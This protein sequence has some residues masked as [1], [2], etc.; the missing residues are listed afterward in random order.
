M[1]ARSRSSCSAASP[2]RYAAAARDASASRS[3]SNEPPLRLPPRITCTPPSNAS[4]PRTADDTLVAFESF[5]YR[6]PPTVPTSSSRCGTPANVRSAAATA[7][8]GTPDAI[9][10]AAAPR[11][12][13]RLCSPRSLISSTGS[14]SGPNS[15]RR[16]E[17]GT[18]TP[19]GTTATCSGV[20]FANRRSFASR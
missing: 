7:S 19:G 10:A 1:P 5:T 16:P 13:S 18:S 4:I 6:T 8:S 2:I 15:T 17:P 3:P 11:A 14:G 9:A 12:F 20:W